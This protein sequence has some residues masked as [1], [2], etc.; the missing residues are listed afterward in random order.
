MLRKIHSGSPPWRARSHPIG[1]FPEYSPVKVLNRCGLIHSSDCGSQH[2]HAQGLSGFL[3]S[4]RNISGLKINVAPSN[5][6][7]VG[8]SRARAHKKSHEGAKLR[9]GGIAGCEYFRN[10]VG[11]REN[12]VG[13]WLLHGDLT[14]PWRGRK[15]KAIVRRPIPASSHGAEIAIRARRTLARSEERRV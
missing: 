2:R 12:V 5:R 13:L 7:R 8:K 4:N 15:R 6:E 3:A 11:C 10:F 14:R 9:A 1:K